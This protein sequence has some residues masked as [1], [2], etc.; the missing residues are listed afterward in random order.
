MPAGVTGTPFSNPNIE[1]RISK[2]YQMTEIQMTKSKNPPEA[3]KLHLALVGAL[4][5]LNFGLVSDFGI[6][7]SNSISL[8]GAQRLPDGKIPFSDGLCP[9]DIATS[10]RKL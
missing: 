3:C 1:A 5:Y 6:R 7:I 4:E 8:H 9:P 2:Q 10:K